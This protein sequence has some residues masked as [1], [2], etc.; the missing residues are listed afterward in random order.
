MIQSFH[1]A[2]LEPGAPEKYEETCNIIR[3]IQANTYQ[4][5]STDWVYLLAGI[6]AWLEVRADYRTYTHEPFA[7]WPHA[8]IIQDIVKAYVY[9]AMFFPELERFCSPATEYFKSSEGSKY[10]DSLLLKPL[11]RSRTVPK[12]RTR[13]SYRYRDKPFWKDWEAIYNETLGKNEWYMDKYP[14]DWSAA[15]RPIIAKCE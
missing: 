11:E 13:T 10:Q 7:P 1:L 5:R 12:H 6:L 8:F 2:D 14:S 9:M 15:I 3:G 4:S